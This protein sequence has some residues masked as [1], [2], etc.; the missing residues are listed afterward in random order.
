MESALYGTLRTRCFCI[1]KLTRSF[2]YA[3]TFHEVIYIC[4][5]SLLKQNVNCIAIFFLIS[6]IYCIIY[7]YM[8]LV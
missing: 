1:K 3:R 8:L 4:L 6:N 5:V 2:S 7:N